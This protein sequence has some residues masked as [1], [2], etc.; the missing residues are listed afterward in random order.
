[1]Q[2]AFNRRNTFALFQRERHSLH[3]AQLIYF[4]NRITA[5]RRVLSSRPFPPLPT[6]FS[7]GTLPMHRNNSWEIINVNWVNRRIL[8]IDPKRELLTQVRT[9]RYDLWF[10]MTCLFYRRILE[11]FQINAAVGMVGFVSSIELVNEECPKVTLVGKL[12]MWILFE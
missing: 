4:I 10:M 3:V 8:F 12:I 2:I 1:M 9:I 11:K 7:H 6:P 5:N